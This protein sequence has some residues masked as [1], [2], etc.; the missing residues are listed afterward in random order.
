LESDAGPAPAAFSLTIEPDLFD[1]NLTHFRG[2]RHN[3]TTLQVCPEPVQLMMMPL[4][5]KLIQ[6]NI[7]SLK[8]TPRW[9]GR[10][11]VRFVPDEEPRPNRFT[12]KMPDQP[13]PIFL[14]IPFPDRKKAL[15]ALRITSWWV[16]HDYRRLI[17]RIRANHAKDPSQVHWICPDCSA[18]VL[19]ERTHCA[20]HVCPSWDTLFLATGMAILRPAVENTA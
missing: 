19:H 7:Q 5:T 11:S 16:E 1:V 20:T 12:G 8:V 10:F 4:I 17:A 2:P 3:T 13:D 9:G 18:K 15:E 6:L 14:E